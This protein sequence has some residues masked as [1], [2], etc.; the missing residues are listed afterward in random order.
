MTEHLL[1]DRLDAFGGEH[2]RDAARLVGHQRHRP[3]TELGAAIHRAA[4]GEHAAAEPHHPPSR[5]D[6]HLAGIADLGADL[7]IEQR[8]SPA[9]VAASA[10]AGSTIMPITAPLARCAISA[11]NSP[12]VSDVPPAPGLSW[13]SARMTGFVAPFDRRSASVTAASGV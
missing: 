3:D 8:P 13:M 9:A 2:H 10:A 6:R 4:A 12:T 7:A 11:R 5:L 1:V